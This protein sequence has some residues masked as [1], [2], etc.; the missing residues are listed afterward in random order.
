MKR[1]SYCGTEYPDDATECAIDKTPFVEVQ[2]E[3]FHFKRPTFAIFSEHQ[4]PVS[5]AIVSYLFFLPAGIF[6][7][8]VAFTIFMLIVAESLAG[9]I[10]GSGIIL[11]LCLAGIAVGIF[12]LCLS[13]GLRRCSRGWRTC[14]LVLTWWGFIL[15]AF[16]II[17]YFLT[18]ATPHH[19]K[20][21]FFWLGYGLGFILQVWQY[22]VLTRPD[23]RDLFG[24]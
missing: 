15:L 21:I 6:F 3:P 14:A 24:V 17:R 5:L 16:G 1:C 20:P 18:H 10:P 13:R 8:L 7:G 2:S 22:R 19:E 4:I 9:G 11:L 23:V 12:Y